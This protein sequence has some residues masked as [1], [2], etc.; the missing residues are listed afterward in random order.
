M[1]TKRDYSRSTI[2]QLTGS[3]ARFERKLCRKD[4]TLA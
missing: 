3:E 1:A 2:Y 4:G